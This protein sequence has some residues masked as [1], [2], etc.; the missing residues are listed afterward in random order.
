MRVRCL[1]AT[2]FALAS[3]ASGAVLAPLG[4]SSGGSREVVGVSASAVTTTYDWLQFNGDPQHSGNNTQE[5]TITAANVGTLTQLFRVTLPGNEDGAPVILTNVVVG[6]ATHDVLFATSV[7]GHLLALDAHTGATLWSM[8]FGPG[9]CLI[10]NAT[11]ACYT[12]SSPA[13]D[14]NRA[15]VYAYGLDGKVHKVSIQGTEVT[16]GGWP[17][18]TTLKPYDEKGSSALAIGGLYL[19]MTHGGYPG[20]HGDYQGHVTAINL[21]TNTQNVFNAQCSNQAVHL[22][23]KPGTPDCAGIQTAIWARSGVV[24]DADLDKIYVATANG[25]Y[26]PTS[27]GWGDSVLALHPNATGASGDPLDSYTPTNFATLQSEDLDLGS[28][29]PAILPLQT[30]SRITI[31]STQDNPQGLAVDATSV[32]WANNDGGTVLK[33]P[34]GGGV[35]TTLAS[36]QDGPFGIAVDATSVYWT[37]EEGGTVMKVPLGGGTTTTLASGQSAPTAITLDSTNVYWTNSGSSTV[38][39]VALGGGTATTLATGQNG[40]GIAVDATSVYLANYSA[41]TV[42]KVPLGGGTVTTLASG[43]GGPTGIAVDATSVYW[44]NRNS[45]AVMK[46]PLDGGTATTLA[47]GLSGPWTLTVYN[48]NVYFGS[49]GS[50][51]AVRS[52]PVGGGTVIVHVPGEGAGLAVTAAGIF[53]INGS[54]VMA[55]PATK[56]FGVQGGKDAM[57]RL[58]NLANLSGQGAPGHTGG[59]VGTPI[60]V[61][62]GGSVVSAPAVWV[63]PA[64]GATWVFVSTSGGVAGIKV[65]FDSSSNPSLT[66]VWSN[67][68]G[69][70]DGGGSPLVANGVL[71]HVSSNNIRALSPTT[72][73]VLWNNTTIATIHWQSPVVANGTLYISDQNRGLTAFSLC[74]SSACT[75]TP[76]T[77]CSA[78]Q[79]CGTISNG[80]NG[81]VTCGT[82]SSGETCTNNTCVVQPVSFSTQVQPIF[83]SNC[84]LSNCHAAGYWVPNLTAGSAY[85]DIVNVTAGPKC[86]TA[87]FVVPSEPAESFL[88]AALT[89]DG[90]LGTCSGGFMSVNLGSS[91]NLETIS[92]WI[93]QGA[94]N[95]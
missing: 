66:P 50:P 47:S 26:A 34:L 29:A 59:E 68:T 21:T 48:G 36:G 12:T 79:T 52:V 70:A 60:S 37:N 82:C 32:Y 86:S 3:V 94:Q 9:A 8:Q 83:T 4:C 49:G 62:G 13:V 20:D 46:V 58:L 91:A 2:L 7:A 92:T 31:A 45:G 71:Y 44:T 23:E 30:P 1:H 77:T 57:L 40:S 33:A 16:T 17:Q 89:S 81:S 74:T 65:V 90:S 11:G 84:A 67:G 87:E 22:V 73:A 64:D 95:N 75:C 56:Y 42:T 14:P 55:Q 18:V 43:Q 78:S 25:T 27:Y 93:S 24:Y 61:P 38:M 28:T 19:Y 35:A 85:A 63:N 69:A 10:N 88:V 39:K 15:Y 6:G 41:G 5:T 51:T 53:W 80:C 72:G 76:I 54:N